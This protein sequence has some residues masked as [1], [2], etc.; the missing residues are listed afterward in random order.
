MSQV[1]S[2]EHMMPAGSHESVTETPEVRGSLAEKMH[3][4]SGQE[5]KARETAKAQEVKAVTRAGR[6][7][8]KLPARATIWPTVGRGCFRE[9]VVRLADSTPH[10]SNKDAEMDAEKREAEGQRAGLGGLL[11]AH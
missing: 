5:G 8:Q 3:V 11:C 6:S 9:P 7:L 2:H 10:S 4:S 1:R